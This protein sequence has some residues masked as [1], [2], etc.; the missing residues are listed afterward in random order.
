MREL[1]ADSRPTLWIAEAVL[2]YLA[3]GAAARCCA[4]CA[5]RGASQTLLFSAMLRA[6]GRQRD[7]GNAS[8]WI[9]RWLA[10]VRKPFRWALP[11][12][13]ALRR[14]LARAGFDVIDQRER[15]GDAEH[16]AGEALTSRVSQPC[17]TRL[18]KITVGASP[19]SHSAFWGRLAGPF[20][21]ARESTTC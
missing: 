1:A 13:D 11:A 6:R 14:V 3:P 12:A 9:A 5:R 18:R 17:E 19:R 4:A 21:V 7:S 8:P 15:D 2:M 10:S 16:C 20:F